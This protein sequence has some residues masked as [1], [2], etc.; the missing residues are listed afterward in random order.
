ML[1]DKLKGKLKLINTSQK[2]MYQTEIIELKQLNREC[3]EITIE[4][5]FESFHF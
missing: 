5:E 4:S 2:I 1:F 3:E